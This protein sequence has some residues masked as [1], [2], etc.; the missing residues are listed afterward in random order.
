ML[1]T[2][3]NNLPCTVV[4]CTPAWCRRWLGLRVGQS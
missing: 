4:Q 3:V 1:T 2:N